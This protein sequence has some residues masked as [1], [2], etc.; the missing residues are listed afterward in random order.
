MT[1][2]KKRMKNKLTLVSFIVCKNIFN[3]SLT[4]ALRTGEKVLLKNKKKLLFLST[5][6]TFFG[7]RGA[8]YIHYKLQPPEGPIKLTLF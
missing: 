2:N 1:K 4:G 3:C 5:K 7:G 8:I 6:R